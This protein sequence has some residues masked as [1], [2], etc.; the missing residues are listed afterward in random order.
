MRRSCAVKPLG[1]G[2]YV[3][4][5]SANFAN[6]SRIEQYMLENCQRTYEFHKSWIDEIRDFATNKELTVIDYD[7]KKQST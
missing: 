2:Y 6:N 1:G 4:E 5:T 7:G 3:C